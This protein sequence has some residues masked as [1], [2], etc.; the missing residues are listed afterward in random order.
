MMLSLW[1]ILT[2]LFFVQTLRINR[3]LQT[4]FISLS[5]LF[6]LLAGGVRNALCNKVS[7][8]APGA[9]PCVCTMHCCGARQDTAYAPAAA[10][11]CAWWPRLPQE[12]GRQAAAGHAVGHASISLLLASSHVYQLDAMS[13]NVLSGWSPFLE[14]LRV[15]SQ[16]S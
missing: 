10:W 7:P 14:V 8:P 1:G 4:L 5:I 2:F 16:I 11:R 9:P 15:F 3:A 12:H 13:C 6:F